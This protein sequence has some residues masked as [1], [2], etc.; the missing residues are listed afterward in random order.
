ME[1]EELP[2]GVCVG[3][4]QLARL[5]GERGRDGTGDHADGHAAPRIQVRQLLESRVARNGEVVRVEVAAR[6]TGQPAR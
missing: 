6:A 4:S 2:D 5:E 1:V 3:L